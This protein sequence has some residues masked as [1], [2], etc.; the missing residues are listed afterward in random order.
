MKPGTLEEV[1]A[2]AHHAL[3]CARAKFL[4]RE[5]PCSTLS[6]EQAARHLQDALAIFHTHMPEEEERLHLLAAMERFQLAVRHF[7]AINAQAAAFDTGW[8][9]RLAEAL[10]AESGFAY[11]PGRQDGLAAAASRIQL[12]A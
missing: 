5:L 12:E 4:L 11:G 8:A 3:E 6:L 1:I 9:A 7:E 10:G 2:S